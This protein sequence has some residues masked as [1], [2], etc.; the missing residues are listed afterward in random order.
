M[1]KKLT[2]AV[3]LAATLLMT[4][5]ATL[6]E[7]GEDVCTSVSRIAGMIMENRQE[8]VPLVDMMRIAEDNQMLRILTL[9]AYN[10]PRY[11]SQ[12][13]KDLAIE[14]FTNGVALACYEQM[15]ELT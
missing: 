12:E 8:G 15:G 11:N 4:T 9:E 1:I 13:H 7:E 2:L 10:T 5:T 14:D 6:A 3:S